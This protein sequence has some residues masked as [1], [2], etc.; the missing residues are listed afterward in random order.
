M[1][2]ILYDVYCV[3]GIGLLKVILHLHHVNVNVNVVVK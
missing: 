1:L 2:F 3:Y